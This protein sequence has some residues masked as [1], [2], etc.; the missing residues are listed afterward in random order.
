MLRY[1]NHSR[2]FFLFKKQGYTLKK[3][4]LCKKM[5]WLSSPPTVERPYLGLRDQKSRGKYYAWLLFIVR[6]PLL[7]REVVRQINHSL[8]SSRPGF[9]PDKQI[10]FQASHH[11]HITY[12]R[13]FLCNWPEIDKYSQI[14]RQSS[15][16]G[17]VHGA[18]YNGYRSSRHQHREKLYPYSPSLAAYGWS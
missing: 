17:E 16:K 18:I 12:M 15:I 5:T 10:L 11:H 14:S 9:E 1:K 2:R 3:I 13:C 6:I 8:I 7:D 4:N